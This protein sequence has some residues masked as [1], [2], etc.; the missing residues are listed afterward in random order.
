V[1][2]WPSSES[3]YT[4]ATDSSLGHRTAV[5]FWVC[6]SS[7]AGGTHYPHVTWPHV[8]LTRAVGGVRGDLTLNS[9]AQIHASATLLTSRDLAWSSGRLTC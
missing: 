8:M 7:K 1:K 5:A 6:T 4:E 2:T 3:V 9:M